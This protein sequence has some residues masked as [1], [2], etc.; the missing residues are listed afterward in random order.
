M[1]VSRRMLIQRRTFIFC[2]LKVHAFLYRAGW[3]NGSAECICSGCTLFESRLACLFAQDVSRVSSVSQGEFLVSIFH[4]VFRESSSLHKAGFVS[5]FQKLLYFYFPPCCGFHGNS[6][7]PNA[8]G[9]YITLNQMHPKAFLPDLPCLIFK[10][11][12]CL[13][14]H[15]LLSFLYT[16]A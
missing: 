9:S 1:A 14:S 6:P 7:F 5:S 8:H 15:P 11:W 3:C 16:S 10:R 13:I 4:Q 12:W 2:T